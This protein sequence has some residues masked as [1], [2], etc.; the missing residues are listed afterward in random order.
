MLRG[1]T[2]P[3]SLT[4]P[5]SSNC[6]PAV[7]TH[8]PPVATPQLPDSDSQLKLLW[9]CIK[10]KPHLKR[11][12]RP[13]HSSKLWHSKKRKASQPNKENQHP[14]QSQSQEKK[15]KDD[16][17]ED[18]APPSKLL[19]SDTMAEGCSKV[20]DKKIYIRGTPAYRARLRHKRKERNDPSEIVKIGD[21]NDEELTEISMNHQWEFDL[22]I[23]QSNSWLND[24]LIN[25]GMNLLKSAYPHVQGMQDC[26]M[27]DTLNF[28][29]PNSDFVQILNCARN[30][31][32]CVSTVGCQP[33]RIN[34]F[35]SMCTG[36]IPLG[37]KE[38]IASLLCTAKKSIT[39]VS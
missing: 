9:E 20:S 34:V 22:K 26:M 39:R 7:S 18:D 27:S 12:G 29:P 1:A 14:P 8:I 38:A 37:T 33:G 35:D 10:V 6:S 21:G 3:V 36:D 31:W 17:P 2:S 15:R 13:K 4:L 24:K 5:E 23:L 32:I 28:E 30:H 25:A 11:R 16:Y 19:K